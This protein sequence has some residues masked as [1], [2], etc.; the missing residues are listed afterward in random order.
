MSIVFALASVYIVYKLYDNVNDTPFLHDLVREAY[1]YSGIDEKLF[2]LFIKHID[3]CKE[4]IDDPT[5][6][7]THL[8]IAL[9]H[10]Q[11]IS[12][13]NNYDV[14]DEIRDLA[15]RIGIEVEQRILQNAIK[16]KKPFRPIYLN[17]RIY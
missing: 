1:T 6:A 11:D 10:L 5:T 17:E 13:Y 2:K 14:Y 3:L 12:M 4:N 16:N 9:D 15:V 8:Y 7:S